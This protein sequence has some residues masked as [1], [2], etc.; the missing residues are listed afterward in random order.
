MTPSERCHLQ[1]GNYVVDNFD[2]FLETLSTL[3]P[4]LQQPN[5]LISQPIYNE[6]VSELVAGMYGAA[7]A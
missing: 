1:V 4:S 7:A 5:P 3:S 2:S 6:N